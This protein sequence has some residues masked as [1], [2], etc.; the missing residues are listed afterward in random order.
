MEETV[1]GTLEPEHRAWSSAGPAL[2]SPVCSADEPEGPLA[3]S[4]SSPGF[5][6]S[7]TAIIQA[8]LHASSFISDT[9]IAYR[10]LF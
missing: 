3:E 7:N 5:L 8:D 10:R 6:K 9:G 2:L 4:D 1:P